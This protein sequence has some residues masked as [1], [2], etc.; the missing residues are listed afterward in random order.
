ME[1]GAN[2]G[3]KLLIHVETGHGIKEKNNQ[4]SM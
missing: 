2:A 3:I 1:A 4:N